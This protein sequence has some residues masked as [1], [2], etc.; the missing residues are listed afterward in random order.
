MTDRQDRQKATTAEVPLLPCLCGNLR[1]ASRLVSQLYESEPGWSKGLTVAQHS[2]LQ[3]IAQS[4]TI[5]H[6]GLGW[7]LGL[8]QTTVS[9]SLATLGKRGWVR[10]ARGEDRR[11]R[12]VTLS[13]EGQRELRRVEHAWRRAQARLRRHYGA[14]EWRNLQR[15]L[16]LLAS[17]IPIPITHDR[18]R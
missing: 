4:G 9:R 17:A 5:T 6:A 2:L 11:E 15:A 3:A 8:D 1:R 14:D 10:F 13:A 7:L 16:T 18:S 12:R